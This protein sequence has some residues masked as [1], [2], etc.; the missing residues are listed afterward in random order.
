MSTIDDE[1]VG[2]FPDRGP[3]VFAV[4]TATLVLASVFVASRMISRI[5]IVKHVSYDD[6]IIVIAW[7]FAFFLS[8][9]INLGTRKGLGRHD[10]NI[11]SHDYPTLRKCEYV[12][13]I[14]YVSAPNDIPYIVKLL[15]GARAHLFL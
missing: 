5:G 7:V 14:L 15:R 10:E 1:M 4:T 9:T 8:F 6:Y 12:F 2:G 3:A 13:S 11:E